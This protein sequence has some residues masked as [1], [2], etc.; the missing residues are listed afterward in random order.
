MQKITIQVSCCERPHTTSLFVVKRNRW[1]WNTSFHPQWLFNNIPVEVKWQSC[2]GDS[3][4]F[5]WQCLYM[6]F[7]VVINFSSFSL[8]CYFVLHCF[9]FYKHFD[10]SN[11]ARLPLRHSNFNIAK[12]RFS[13]YWKFYKYSLWESEYF[14]LNWEILAFSAK[15]TVL[16]MV[17]DRWVGKPTKIFV[18]AFIER[19]G[20]LSGT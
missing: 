11:E 18:E 12:E 17:K 1:Q 2:C 9:S 13:E 7:F 14:P 4:T 5:Q 3:I 10:F 16:W 6:Q 8:F 20:R 19:S 15:L